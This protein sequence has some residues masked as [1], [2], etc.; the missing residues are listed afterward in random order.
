MSS[1]ISGLAN[2]AEDFLNTLDSS[3]AEALSRR[4]PTDFDPSISEHVVTMYSGD[5]DC[6][7]GFSGDE[8]YSRVE[9][10]RNMFD[11]N[12][13]QFRRVT[14]QLPPPNDTHW[15][16][17]GSSGYGSVTDTP[18][19]TTKFAMPTNA[20]DTTEVHEEEKGSPRHVMLN[21][22]QPDETRSVREY[23]I[24]LENKLLHSEVSSLNQELSDLLRRNHKTAEENKELSGKVDR[25]T[26]RLRDAD[27]QRRDL[28]V[29]VD[30]LTQQLAHQRSSTVETEE[31]VKQLAAMETD[32]TGARLQL[33]SNKQ[34]MVSALVGS[35]VV[36]MIK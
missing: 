36:V 4:S 26:N 35:L 19:S 6:S 1:W 17:D 33:D 28:R 24:Q 29:S 31:L 8:P 16:T 22:S 9:Q 23:D 14:D 20:N 27:S 3:A 13:P 34:T 7:S 25:L 21:L 32:L 18:K 2:K 30:E 5:D 15:L 10:Q 11:F 12:P